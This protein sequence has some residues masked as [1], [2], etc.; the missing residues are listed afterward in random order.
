MKITQEIIKNLHLR[1][2]YENCQ[3]YFDVSEKSIVIKNEI[4]KEA[5]VL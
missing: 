1:E 4:T 5:K 2:I 3:V